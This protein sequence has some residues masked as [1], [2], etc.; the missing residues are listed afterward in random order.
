MTRAE[1]SALLACFSIWMRPFVWMQLMLIKRAQMR[2]RRMVM[3]HVCYATGRLRVVYI[4]D[5]PC[6]PATWQYDVPANTALD[7]LSLAPPA[8]AC[9]SIRA[10]FGLVPCIE[11]IFACPVTARPDT[12]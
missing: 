1:I 4:A 2:H 8:P 5:A 12:S 3:V 11:N 7:R 9:R 10:P 6:A